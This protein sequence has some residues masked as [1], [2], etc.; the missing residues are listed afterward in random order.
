[1]TSPDFVEGLADAPLGDL[2]EKRAECRRVEG[3]VSYL[4]RVVQGQVD[5]VVAEMGLRLSGEAGDHDRLLVDDLPRI[6]AGPSSGQAEEGRGQVAVAGHGPTRH[7]PP[8]KARLPANA[9]TEVFAWNPDLSLEDI[10]S[11]IAPELAASVF[12]GGALPGASLAS[13]DDAGL[14]ELVAHLSRHEASLSAM[15]R[16]L[17]ERIDTLEEMVSERY[18]EGT[19]RSEVAAEDDGTDDG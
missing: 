11:V 19:G 1:M 17:H 16:V 6:L 12:R 13:F 5:L 3:L 10:A 7:G 9:V 8:N 4:R 2:R 15:R 18:E 14:T